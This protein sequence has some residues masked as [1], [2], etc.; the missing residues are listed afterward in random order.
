MRTKTVEPKPEHMAFRADILAL[1]DKHSGSLP[2]VEM[3]ALSSHLVGQIL[4]MQDQRSLTPTM[5]MELIKSNV[6]VGNAE[7]I[8]EIMSDSGKPI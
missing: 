7:A 8:A 1:L 6:E 4:A 2:A 5:G 3:L